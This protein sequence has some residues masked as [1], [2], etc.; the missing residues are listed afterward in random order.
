MPDM[1]INKVVVGLA[2]VPDYNYPRFMTQHKY[3]QIS[4]SGAITDVFKYT[5]RVHLSSHFPAVE[6]F[7]RFL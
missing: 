6:S 1:V 7:Q 2:N 5:S 4:I 3:P